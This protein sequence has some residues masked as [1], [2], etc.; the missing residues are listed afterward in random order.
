MTKQSPEVIEVNNQQLD[1]LLNRAANNT[2]RKED[3]ELMQNIFQSYTQFFEIVR[4]K[5]SSIARLR[6][7]MFG[8]STEKTDTVVG[9]TGEESNDASDADGEGES[10][11][12]PDSEGDKPND[13]AKPRPPGHGRRAA[14]DY[15]GGQQVEIPH[16]TLTAGDAC[17]AC[18]QGTLYEKKPGVL[19]RFTGQAPL[20]ATVY[21]MQ[22]L[23]CHVC[24]KVFTASA[25]P[26]IGDQK[27]DHTA[28]SMIALLK[29]GSGLPFNRV[30]RLQGNLEIPLAASTQWDIVDTAAESLAP[31]YQ[32]LIQQAAQGDVVYND[33]T[34]VRILELMGKRARQNPPDDELGPNRTG[35]FTS[36]VVAMRDG[37]SVALFFSGRQH[38]GENLS[39]VLKHRVAELDAPIQM[40]DGLSRNLPKELD[41]IL[42]NCIA[43]ARRKFVELYD[44]F[45][46][47]CRYVIEAFRVIYTNDKIARE[48]EMTAEERLAY[49]Q[50]LSKPTMD[51]L[52]EW[53]QRQFD[54]GLVEPNSAL[55]EAINY[56]LKRWDAMTLFLRKAGAPLDNNICERALKKAILHRKNSM[57]YKTRNGARVG[58][59][60]MSLIHTCELNGA[61]P[62]DY[63]NQLQLNAEQAAGQPALWLPWN[64]R[65]NQLARNVA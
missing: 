47:E 33:D 1:D 58:D 45:T 43:H 57:F 64:Y 50:S 10:E 11:E 4:D 28:A 13:S 34:T 62:F 41:T 52:R 54:D 51:E 49:H 53:L 44:R 2:L 35:L 31:V 60:Y 19:V 48:Q 56:L 27:Y 36:G 29:Y 8:A 65:E 61:N 20:Q 14:D 39:D 30:Q 32:E 16:P 40:C 18:D 59:L 25:P 37:V 17:P 55:G 9:K 42:S 3:T 26:D 7:M 5:N 46:D 6:K 12:P 21:R 15:T 63:L 38:A 22:K 24:G 23:R